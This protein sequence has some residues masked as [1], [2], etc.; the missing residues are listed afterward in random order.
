MIGTHRYL[1]H[2]TVRIFMQQTM[3]VQ[4]LYALFQILQAYPEQ[5]ENQ[6]ITE[7]EL[8]SFA[9]IINPMWFMRTV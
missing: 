2:S 8:S 4:L 7:I 3:V 9:K 6:T 5:Y 1:Q